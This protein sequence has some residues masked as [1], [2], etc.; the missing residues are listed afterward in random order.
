MNRLIK[1]L[2]ASALLP[3]LL[4]A[5]TGTGELRAQ[6]GISQDDFDPAAVMTAASPAELL[7]GQVSGVLVGAYSGNPNEMLNV[8][9]RGVNSLRGDNQPL[10]IIDGTVLGNAPV[11][12]GDTYSYLETLDPLA[13]ISPHDICGIEVLKDAS[14][15]ALYGARGANGVIIIRTMQSKGGDYESRLRWRSNMTWDG[16]LAHNHYLST[17]GERNRFCYN[18]SGTYRNTGGVLGRNGSD[19]AGLKLNFGS[20]SNSVF[21][22]GMNSLFSLGKSSNP[23]ATAAFGDGSMT[24]AMR[25]PVLSGGFSG[26][27]TER[28]S[29]GFSEG[30]TG[31]FTEEDWLADH[32]DD[33]KEYRSVSSAYVRLNIAKV[34]SWETS[35][36]ADFRN[37]NR[38]VWDGDRTPKGS[39]MNGAAS[40]INHTLFNYNALST[41]NYSQF[42]A[43]HHRLSASLAVELFGNSN[44][45]NTMNGTDFFSKAL[46]AKGLSLMKS[47]V[48][49]HKF[50]RAEFRWGTFATLGYSYR[51]IVGA[52]AAV[53]ADFSPKY[54][55]APQWFPSGKLWWNII[56]QLKVEGGYGIAGREL[57]VPYELTGNYLTG[58]WPEV[59][60][61]TAVW[62][63]GLNRVRS[64]EYHAGLETNLFKDRLSAGLKFYDRRSADNY[65]IFSFCER[66]GKYLR[67]GQRQL[68]YSREA[69][70]RN[71]GVEL[72]IDA[73]PVRTG[74]VTWSIGLNGTYNL[75]RVLSA[76]DDDHFGPDLGNGLIA[77][78]HLAGYPAS[79]ILG[80]ELTEDNE[81]KDIDGDGR[82]TR[83]D[84]VVI[85]NSQPL[86]HTA[87][88]T[89]V[90]WKGLTLG[91]TLT[92]AGG[93]ELMNLNTLA[94]NGEKELHKGYVEKGDYLRISSLSIRYD[95][96]LRVKWLKGLSVSISGRNLLT[97]T[98]YSGYDPEVDS[99]GTSMLSRGLD[100]GSCPRR[101]S[102]AVGLSANF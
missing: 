70:V 63:D 33:S 39:A 84:M 58:T 62:Y 44:V 11:R 71:T 45:S 81:L 59:D 102:A 15:T 9:V 96:P 86:W 53:R 34:L 20:R 56:P 43:I 77:S 7:R 2:H 12:S 67:K 80:Y 95:I 55:N 8:S 30:L 99:Y 47:D 46:R 3:L 88:R 60:A 26:K 52:E 94:A 23:A 1:L 18:I 37:S 83:E 31:K 69:Q 4:F 89:D 25:N 36:G 93:N 16:R 48:T 78:G 100:Y 22:F 82:I 92:A 61:D 79:A 28:F 73:V 29:E 24:T 76:T 41:L 50:S 6:T 57:Y 14:A 87:L 98:R 21:Q 74:N 38:Y 97:L 5:L 91:M 66:P 101:P 19:R 75:N 85:G 68:Q 40:I 51:D 72:D 42:V 32:D 17:S 13:F 54:G 49:L 65:S 90:R 35:V 27:F 64:E 10:W